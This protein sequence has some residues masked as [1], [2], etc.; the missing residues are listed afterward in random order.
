ME[1]IKDFEIVLTLSTSE[2]FV[3]TFY[4]YFEYV[5]KNYSFRNHSVRVSI[6]AYKSVKITHFISFKKK[7]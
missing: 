1:I 6:H 7:L 3:K 4:E 2:K 5:L